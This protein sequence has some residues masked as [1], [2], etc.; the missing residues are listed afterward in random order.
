M[1]DQMQLK[2][3]IHTSSEADDE[4][5]D[6]LARQLCQEILDL[7]VEDVSLVE[8][9][10]APVGAKGDPIALGVLLVTAL[11]SGTVFPHLLDLLKSW[12]TRH[13]LRSVTLEID[14]DKLE[15]K[16]VSAQEQQQLIDAWMSRHKLI[17]T[18]GK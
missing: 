17:L 14:G 5:L 11:T 9:G 7:D 3:T 8:T 15:V 16:G 10:E 4:E 2:L 1:Q 13:G 6:R 18:P 12:L